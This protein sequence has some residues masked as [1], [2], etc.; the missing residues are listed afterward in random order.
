MVCELAL[1]PSHLVPRAFVAQVPGAGAGRL[2]QAVVAEPKLVV[3][4]VQCFQNE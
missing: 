1:I 2:P 3:G 4:S